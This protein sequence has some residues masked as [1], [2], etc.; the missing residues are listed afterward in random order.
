MVT[1]TYIYLYGSRDPELPYQET[2]L[3]HYPMGQMLS[4]QQH[5]LI[6]IIT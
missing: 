4:I 1:H 5:N 6:L 2:N 3:I